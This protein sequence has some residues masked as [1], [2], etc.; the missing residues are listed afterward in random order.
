MAVIEDREK[1]DR[2][3]GHQLNKNKLRLGE[4]AGQVSIAYPLFSK[5][6]GAAGIFQYKETGD[7]PECGASEQK[8]GCRS[9]LLSSGPVWDPL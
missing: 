7:D 6:Q 2:C 3:C 1:S 9:R 8:T 5:V 4:S